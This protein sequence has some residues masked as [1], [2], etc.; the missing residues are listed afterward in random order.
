[1]TFGKIT[2]DGATN[3]IPAE[4]KLEGTF[5]TMDEK[6]RA[7]AH[8]QMKSIA[9]GIVEGMGGTVDFNI[10]GGYPSLIND[11]ELTKN[12][13]AW[14]IE[15]LGAENVIDLPIR[16]TAEDFAY[17][18]QEMPACF[19]RLGIRNE[20][21]GITA[22]LHTSRFNV[23]EDALRLSTGLMAWLAVKELS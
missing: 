12:A 10:V 3:V 23:D 9:T 14:A 6:W 16:M 18:S 1:M 15:Y 20:A 11:E 5:R 22:P 4:V 19:Y 2:A 8:Q 17:Y 13:K 7:E 21:K